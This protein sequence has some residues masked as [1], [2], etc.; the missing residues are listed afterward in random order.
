M[1]LG[2]AAAVAPV[3]EV[4]VAAFW[5]A[6]LGAAGVVEAALEL[7]GAEEV[8]DEVEVEDWLMSVELLDGVAGA[9]LV[10][11]GAVEL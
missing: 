9:A 7:A 8:L 2:A 4:E 5:S 10:D 6:V 11:E 1:L 3:P